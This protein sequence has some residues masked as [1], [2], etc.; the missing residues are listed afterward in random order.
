[1]RLLKLRDNDELSLAEF[2]GNDIPPYAIL[3]HT[4]GADH[5]E[6]TFKDLVD[7]AGKSKA[8]YNKILFC[9]KQAAKNGL[10]YFWVDTCCI[11]KSSSAELTE[12]LNSMFRWYQNAD[13]C[14][15]YLSDVSVNSSVEDE[16]FTRRW[17][18][19]FRR[20][21]WFNRGWTLQELIAPTSVE[22]FSKEEQRLSDKQSLEQTLHEIT[23]I[24]IQALRGSPLSEFD[25]DER[26]S[27]AAK[28]KTKREEDEAYSLLG[29][30]DI[31]MPLIYG[32]GRK[33]ALARLQ[34]QVNEEGNMKDGL[35]S[36]REEQITTMLESLRFEQLNTRQMTIK[37]AHAKTCKWLLKNSEYLRWLDPTRLSE[38]HG[39]LWVKGNPGTGKS[40]LMKFALTNARRKMQD[41]VVISFFF[42]ARGEH[43]EKSTIGTYRS[44]LLQLLDK[45]PALQDVFDSLGLSESSINTHYQWSVELLKELLEQAIRRLG[46]TSVVCFIDALDE[47]EERQV[48]DMISFFEHVGQL[49][50][51]AGIQFHVCVSSR[52]YPN[53]TIQKNVELVLEGQEGHSQDIVNYLNSELKIGNTKLAEQIRVEVQEKASGIFMW[54]ILVVGILNEEH[55]RGR[56]HGLRKRL[57][58]IPG[59][60]HELFRDILTRDSRNKDELVLCIQ[61]VLFARQPLSPEQLYFAILSGVEPETLS[62]WNSDE[63][64]MNDIERFILSSSKGL[65]EITKSKFPKAQFIHESVKDFLIEGNGLADIWP[66]LKSNFQG[67]SHERL[68]QCCLTYMGSA[69]SS[70]L[71][72]SKNHSNS[73]K[74]E[75]MALRKSTTVAFPFLEYA[76]LNMLYHADVAEGGGISQSSFIERFPLAD[77]IKINNLLEIHNV[78]RHTE[79]ASLLY[80]LAERNMPH[81]IR[82]YPSILSYL[83]VEEERY[84]TPLFAAL[85]TRSEAAVQTF[86]E[87]QLVNH[88]PGSWLHGLD[89][90]CP[91]YFGRNFKFSTRRTIASYLAELGN[92]V[93]FA[94]ALRSGQ[95]EVD[96]KD[97]DGRTPLLWAAE[98]GHEAVVKLL[99][100]TGQV[101]VDLKDHS[102]QTPLLRAA[103]N[104]H[105]A[106]VKLLLD[107]G[108][109]EVDFKDKFGRTPLSWAAEN[110]HEAVV[111]LLLDTGQVEVDLKNSSG[112]TPLLRAAVKGHEAVVKLLLDTGQVE[113]DLKD[114]SGLTP[115]SWAVEKG[116]EAV[117]KLLLD[118]G[119]VEVNLKDYSGLTPL[120]R[121]AEKGNEA[122]VKLLLD[123]GQI[124]VD[125]KDTFG[126]TPL[127]WAAEKGYEAVVKLLLDTGQVEVNL[128]D[129]S[130]LTPLL[131]AA[132]MGYEA[133]VKLLL[134]TGQIEVD[135]KD[136]FG[137]TPLFWA[138]VSGNEAVAKLLLDTGQ[139]EVNLKDSL[140]KT[141]LAW[142]AENGH[143]AVVKLLLDTGQIEVDSKDGFGRTPLS[144]AAVS[145]HEAVAK[146]LLDT[147]Q[148]EV[149][150]TDSFGR[151]A[152]SWAARMGHEAVVKLLLDTGQVE[153]NLKDYS[154]LT[155][156]SWATKNR[157]ETVVKLLHASLF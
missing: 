13:R 51:I 81:L 145:G 4:W 26:M 135:S 63:T 8:G 80:I 119:Q 122:V 20:S 66:D 114:Y 118:T 116:H 99:L 15:V 94:L 35:L 84:G 28:R 53:I 78:R 55:D 5:D 65:A 117:V 33:K 87:V 30:F 31:H 106:V 107:T 154:G 24:A 95:V 96:L 134:D 11:D 10:D 137:R 19:A 12:A 102:G 1:M 58:E 130:G 132:R 103:E 39:F 67:Q 143:E 69:I 34:K 41:S 140:E 138:A 68:K 111:K 70:N 144:W 54:V 105:E 142:A 7:G 16:E 97:K 88:P 32:E 110:G 93:I 9:G 133:V 131:R 36:L 113:V 150:L 47:C 25:V 3:S 44:L 29:I 139:V 56:M 112:W 48:R 72:F 123:T 74:E 82:A 60:L 50:V 71:G 59:D 27:W 77:W 40:T 124:E 121:A 156:L 73:S 76:A 129:Y 109:I 91:H 126:R 79:N 101:E 6:V 57:K 149:D 14:Y 108:Q 90:Y 120:L 152:L 136:G 141:P 125:S 52:H 22:F 128:K 45:L 21:R 98:K 92:E 147:G 43:L 100:D 37:N 127:L 83:K 2:F 115:L 155:P 42:N 75:A 62:R 148:V 151:T 23:G 157:H 85:A 86:L 38:H 153:V 104:G 89:Q 146:L 18:P 64:P 61:W 46:K 49:V 17:K